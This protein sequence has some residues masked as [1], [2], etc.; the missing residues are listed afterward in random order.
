MENCLRSPVLRFP[1]VHLRAGGGD[2]A[3]GCRS[4]GGGSARGW[5]CGVTACSPG[6][7][8]GAPGRCNRASPGAAGSGGAAYLQVGPPVGHPADDDVGR[9]HGPGG[10]EAE[11]H[12][13]SGAH[14][15][16]EGE[17]AAPR[18][19][20]QPVPAVGVE[21]RAVRQGPARAPRRRAAQQRPQQQQRPGAHPRALP[22]GTW[23]P[24]D[25]RGAARGAAAGAGPAPRPPP[26]LGRG[27]GS[28][29]RPP[30][31]GCVP[32]PSRRSTCRPAPPTRSPRSGI[33][34]EGSEGRPGR[35]GRRQKPRK[36]RGRRELGESLALVG[37]RGGIPGKEWETDERGQVQPS[38]GGEESKDQKA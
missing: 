32:G 12:V 16:A 17:P 26:A 18:A 20:A 14:L 37:E 1:G 31:P 13:A 4:D 38:R 23:A 11:A 8:R 2:G 3:P 35:R 36:A 27:R 33:G 6:R 25:W 28:T 7:E 19:P 10:R 21:E 9:G 5:R 29:A 30:H 22:P 34:G 15:E 24:A